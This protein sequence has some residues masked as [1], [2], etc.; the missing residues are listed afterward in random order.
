MNNYP[1]L[2]FRVYSVIYRALENKKA[3]ITLK[4]KKK[5]NFNVEHYIVE[6]NN[7]TLKG[8]AIRTYKQY[9]KD[10]NLEKFKEIINKNEK[11]IF[12]KFE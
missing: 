8:S 9:F 7:P 12:E 10:K 3:K 5:G 11:I 4:H 1:I 2:S 6:I